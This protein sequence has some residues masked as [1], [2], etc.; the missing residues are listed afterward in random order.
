MQNVFKI[1]SP[2]NKLTTMKYVRIF[3]DPRRCS[4]KV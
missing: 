2:E 1:L 3:L 4:A